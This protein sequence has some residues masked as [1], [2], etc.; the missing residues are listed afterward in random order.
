M[1][2]TFK[3]SIGPAKVSAVCHQRIAK[4]PGPIKHNAIL[5][6]AY[7][8]AV[9]EWPFVN[10]DVDCKLLVHIAFDER[11]PHVG[12]RVVLG[13]LIDIA[14]RTDRILTRIAKD[15]FKTDL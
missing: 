8:P 11:T 10:S 15:V 3:F 14:N 6:I 1:L 5:A 4:N 12:G 13:T 2:E 7:F 9:K